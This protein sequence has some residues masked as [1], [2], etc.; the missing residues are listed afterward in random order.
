M[1]AVEIEEAISELAEQEFD[2]Q[3]FPYAFLE[4]FGNKATTIQ[5]LKSGA[6][7]KS[8]LDGVLDQQYPY[9]G[10]SARRG[11]PDTDRAQGKPGD[12]TGKSE[13]RAGHRWRGF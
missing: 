4:A 9:Q 12:G 11:D 8:D 13:V 1:N 5:R 6:T 2:A 7:N 10:L 3:A